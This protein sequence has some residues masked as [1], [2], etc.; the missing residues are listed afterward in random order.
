LFLLGA[1]LYLAW[2]IFFYDGRMPYGF[3]GL[4]PY[5]QRYDFPGLMIYPVLAACALFAL[6]QLR[7]RLPWAQRQFSPS[8]LALCFVLLVVNLGTFSYAQGRL[9]PVLS[10]VETSNRNTQKMELDLRSSKIL[11]DRHPDWPV[12]VVAVLPMDYEAAVSAS[13][14]FRFYDMSNPI[15]LVVAIPPAEITSASYRGLVRVMEE[16]SSGGDKARGYVPTTAVAVARAQ[17]Q[18]HCYVVNFEDVQ[19]PCTKLTYRPDQYFP[20][21]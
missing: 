19:S 10:A 14:W 12:F 15:S 7:K 8:A 3:D 9:L 13:N 1:G 2:E 4:M 5:G 17:A 16:I 6:F 18:G 11:A 20:E 21:H